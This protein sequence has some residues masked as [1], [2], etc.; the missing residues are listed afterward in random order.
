MTALRTELLSVVHL[1]T[2][3]RA[4]AGIIQPCQFRFQHIDLCDQ[5]RCLLEQS[6]VLFFRLA[7]VLHIIAGT[8]L[9]IN[10]LE[11]IV[12]AVDHAAYSCTGSR[13]FGSVGNFSCHLPYIVAHFP[14][15]IT[16]IHLF[17]LLHKNALPFS[18]TAI[19]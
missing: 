9:L 16:K 1:R 14:K 17:F 18:G 6:L 7:L 10:R 13:L 11:R 12:A 5:I 15:L 8:D 19:V 4:N 3:F 2:A